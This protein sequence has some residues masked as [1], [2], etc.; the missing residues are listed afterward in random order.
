MSILIVLLCAFLAAVLVGLAFR[1]I[2][3]AYQGIAAVVA[4]VLVL[5]VQ[6]GGIR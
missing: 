5:L 2:A 1:F 3:P 6:L 4:F